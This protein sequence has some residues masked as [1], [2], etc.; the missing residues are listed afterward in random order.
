MKEIKEQDEIIRTLKINYK[1]SNDLDDNPP[2]NFYIEIDSFGKNF[3]C[4][5][6]QINRDSAHPI[7]NNHVYTINNNGQPRRHI[8]QQEQVKR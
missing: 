3:T 4:K 7:G 6:V 2:D 1:D 5:F 8:F